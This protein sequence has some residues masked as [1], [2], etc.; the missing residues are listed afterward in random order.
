MLLKKVK[1]K[2]QKFR[3]VGG[4][5]FTIMEFCGHGGR[6]TF[7][8]FR[9]QGGLKHGNH[10]CLGMDIFWNCPICLID[11][12]Q[13]LPSKYLKEPLSGQDWQT[14]NKTNSRKC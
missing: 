3:R 9:R 5:G 7:W 11:E 4:G 14:V 2:E 12:N 10:P 13:A 8:N 1:K 6:K